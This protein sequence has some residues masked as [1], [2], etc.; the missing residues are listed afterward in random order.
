MPRP[1]Q[2]F[3]ATH[4]EHSMASNENIAAW[5]EL[6]EAF[7]NF[8]TQD[9]ICENKDDMRALVEA[10]SKELAAKYTDTELSGMI[11]SPDQ[12]VARFRQ[13]LKDRG[14]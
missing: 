13:F 3:P 9:G 12:A 7:L 6:K 5:Q 10:F 2:G 14:L 8:L 1:L 11:N 4:K